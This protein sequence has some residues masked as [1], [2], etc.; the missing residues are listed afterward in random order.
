MIAS[1]KQRQEHD[2]LAIMWRAKL[3]GAHEHSKEPLACPRTQMWSLTIMHKGS[4]WELLPLAT[5]DEYDVNVT[6]TFIVKSFSK[7]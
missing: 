5:M 4:H 3:K 7:C 2:N 6:N 1:N